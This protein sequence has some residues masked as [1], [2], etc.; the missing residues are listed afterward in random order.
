M[1]YK[2]FST[3]QTTLE[4]IWFYSFQNWGEAQ[5]EQYLFE[6]FDTFEKLSHQH[7]PHK[8]FAEIKGTH[9]EALHYCKCNK[10]F[11]FFKTLDADTI[12]II[13]I[14]HETMD[15]PARLHAILTQ[16][17]DLA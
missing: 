17:E 16:N 8:T 1:A 7:L 4:D 12:G 5:A 3:A 2:L 14:F 13:A 9:G 11:I 6:L 15:M 10:H